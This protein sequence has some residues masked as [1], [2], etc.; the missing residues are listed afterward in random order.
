MHFPGIFCMNN[1]PFVYD[2]HQ[3]HTYAFDKDISNFSIHR[4]M[5]RITRKDFD[6]FKQFGLFVFDFK[7]TDFVDLDFIQILIQETIL[8]RPH[9]FLFK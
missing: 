2:Q 7:N 5:P 3:L 1:L 9:Y 6:C 8:I 4:I